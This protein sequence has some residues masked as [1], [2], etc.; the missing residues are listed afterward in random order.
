MDQG[1]MNQKDDLDAFNQGQ[2][3]AEGRGGDHRPICDNG[4][5]GRITNIAGEN[6]WQ[7]KWPLPKDPNAS[8]PPVNP[9][10]SQGT[11]NEFGFDAG[12][13]EVGHEGSIADF[14]I[15]GP[16]AGGGDKK[17]TVKP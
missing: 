16:S 8:Y 5:A 12:N 15:V 9:Q 1:K 2:G 3:E 11:V 7:G 4:T 17:N 13:T 14:G 6:T 10:S